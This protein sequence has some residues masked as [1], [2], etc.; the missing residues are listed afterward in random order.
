MEQSALAAAAAATTIIL[1]IQPT[2]TDL[3]TVEATLQLINLRDKRACT[4]ALITRVKNGAKRKD[5]ATEYLTA[6]RIKVCPI[7]ISDRVSVQDA[8][9]GGKGIAELAPSSASASE[10][11]A[12]YDHIIEG[13]S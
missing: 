7:T 4:T 8:F 13:S 1:P 10:F 6:N 11:N 9:A 5:S 2:Y 12:A 3:A